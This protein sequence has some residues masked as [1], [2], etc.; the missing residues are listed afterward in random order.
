MP[1]HAAGSKHLASQRL[2]LWPLGCVMLCVNSCYNPACSLHQWLTMEVSDVGCQNISPAPVVSSDLNTTRTTIL[3]RL[4]GKLIKISL[5]CIQ[6][7]FFNYREDN[8]YKQDVSS[9]NPD[10]WKWELCWST[11]KK[12]PSNQV[13]Y[14]ETDNRSRMCSFIF[15]HS[16]CYCGC[17]SHLMH[18]VQ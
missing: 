6:Y 9:I 4:W 8:C 10:K 11:A 14:P 15:D 16:C 3:F 18:P 1:E 5:N 12:R 17:F 7:Y 13:L 2:N